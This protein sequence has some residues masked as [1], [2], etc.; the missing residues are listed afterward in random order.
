MNSDNNDN[1]YQPSFFTIYLNSSKKYSDIF[2]TE[3]ERHLFHEYTHFLEDI[4][5]TYG[6]A[7]LSQVLNNI[8]SLY[9]IVQDKKKEGDFILCNEELDEITELNRTLFREYTQ[10]Q[11]DIIE[12]S[13]EAFITDCKLTS[14]TIKFPSGENKEVFVGKITLNDESEY[15][16]G[17]Q[18]IME[19]ISYILENNSYDFPSDNYLIP[20]DLPFLVWKYYL[21]SEEGNIMGLLELEEFSLGFYNPIEIFIKTL[22]RIKSGEM[23]ITDIN[24]YNLNKRWQSDKKEHVE[25]LYKDAYDKVIKDINGVFV[26]PIYHI[27]KDWLL[28]IISNA[29]KQHKPLIPMFSNIFTSCNKSNHSEKLEELIKCYGVPPIINADGD[30]YI[31]GVIENGIMDPEWNG[32]KHIWVLVLLSFLSSLAI[33]GVYSLILKDE[34]TPKC[35]LLYEVCNRYNELAG[36]KVFDVD[37]NCETDPQCKRINDNFFCPFSVVWQTFGLNDMDVF[38]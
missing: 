17:E 5:T 2:G 7:C 13:K 33:Y 1:F 6:L 15:F 38:K 32:K 19:S 11:K 20:Y 16:M 35:C 37:N 28:N 22:E 36:I 3:D 14:K 34:Q 10:Y 24:Y 9:H 8:K 29:R 21:P 27:Y 23:N 31:E 4:S 12:I 18:A 30:I 26:S 25:D